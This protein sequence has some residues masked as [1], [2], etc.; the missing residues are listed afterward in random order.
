MGKPMLTSSRKYLTGSQ[1]RACMKALGYIFDEELGYFFKDDMC[2]F[3]NVDDEIDNAQD[4]I[5]VNGDR[6]PKY[7]PS[8]IYYYINIGVKFVI[9][10]GAIDP[11]G[12]K[13][14]KGLYCTN[15]RELFS[16]KKKIRSK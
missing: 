14:K 11:Q 6:C 8:A 12:I 13:R 3:G 9:G 1:Y 2:F 16:D 7:S 15:Y 5:K 4:L 10:E